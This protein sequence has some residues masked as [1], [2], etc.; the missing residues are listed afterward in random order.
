[1]ELI[2]LANISSKLSELF[3]PPFAKK[4]RID[5]NRITILFEFRIK[6]ICIAFECGNLT[7]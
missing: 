7:M 5:L 6:P 1:M 4:A 3:I 2:P